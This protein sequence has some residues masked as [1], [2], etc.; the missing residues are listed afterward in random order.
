MRLLQVFT[1]VFG[2]VFGVYLFL[3]HEKLAQ[4]AVEM[5]RSRGVKVAER[6]HKVIL[7]YGSLGMVVNGLLRLLAMIW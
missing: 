6:F 1:H 2:I 3:C 4:A 5:Q 7:K